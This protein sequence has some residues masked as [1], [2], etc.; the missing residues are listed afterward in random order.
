MITEIGEILAKLQKNGVIDYSK[1]HEVHLLYKDD[2]KIQF[3]RTELLEVKRFISLF[4]TTSRA[5]VYLM[6]NP[7]SLTEHQ[8]VVRTDRIMGAISIPQTMKL[9]TKG[10][11]GVVCVEIKKNM[12]T[13]ANRLLCNTL[14]AASIFCDRYMLSEGKLFSEPEK[15]LDKSTM[16]DIKEIR[17]LLSQLLSTK[18]T[19]EILQQTVNSIEE[20]DKD[21]DSLKNLAI[22]NRLPTSFL[23]LIQFFQR[24]KY[25]L[26]VASTKNRT[27]SEIDEFLKHLLGYHFFELN[28]ESR[29]YESW[30]CF[31]ILEG[32]AENFDRIMFE[33][34]SRNGI[35]FKDKKGRISVVYQRRFKTGWKPK[36]NDELEDKP[37]ITVELDGKV[38]LVIDAKNSPCKGYTYRRDMSEYLN[39]SDGK[40][41][42][43]IHSSWAD[44]KIIPEPVTRGEKKI[45]WTCFVPGEEIEN[46]RIIKSIISEVKL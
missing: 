33:R 9:Q 26:W 14:L 20:I 36:T 24:W 6:D 40:K 28:D 16:N 5:L 19:R 44:N 42:I 46:K 25:F 30:I 35:L 38:M 34:R 23:S 21:L 3:E 4:K 10:N 13:P 45:L 11:D 1:T 8:N 17:L 15:Q 43:L 29:L 22:Q 12:N 2:A 41:G 18:F 37:D 32:I 7:H 31:K 39:I 27:S